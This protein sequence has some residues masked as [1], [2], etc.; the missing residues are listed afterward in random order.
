[1]KTGNGIQTSRRAT[2]ERVVG[3]AGVIVVLFW[4]AGILFP[5]EWPARLFTS[6]RTAFNAVFFAPWTHEPTH[7]AL[8]FVL[9]CLLSW[10]LLRAPSPLLRRYAGALFALVIV[11]IALSQEGIQLLYLNRP[12]GE[13]EILDVGVDMAGAAIGALTFWLWKSRHSSKSPG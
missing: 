9:G 7:F 5:F 3:C 11:G 12:P 4:I 10:L 13:P 1:M 8:F 2:V 6:Y